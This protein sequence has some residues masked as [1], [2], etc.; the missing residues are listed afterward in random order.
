MPRKDGFPYHVEQG[1]NGG[2]RAVAEFA[3]IH[4]HNVAGNLLTVVE[5]VEGFYDGRIHF[6][7]GLMEKDLF[8]LVY[9][10]LTGF[11]TRLHGGGHGFER[12]FVDFP[13]LHLEVA[14]MGIRG[15][16]VGPAQ[17]D[18]VAFG[19]RM[20]L[21]D[22]AED[23]RAEDARALR[24]WTGG[25]EDNSARAVA[26]D[27]TVPVAGIDDPAES[28]GADD[29]AFPGKPRLYKGF[30]LDE[31]LE[32]AG[33]AEQQVVGYAS[34]VPD[35]KSALYAGGKSGHGIGLIGVLEDIAEI[36]RNDELVDGFGVRGGILEGSGGGQGGH[37]GS[38]HILM[39]ISSLGNTRDL[40]EFTD[41]LRGIDRDALPAFVIEFPDGKIPVR[42]DLARYIAACACYKDAHNV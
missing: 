9:I 37:I 5:L 25:F 12:E 21:A 14:R 38:S 31:T 24:R 19:Q 4:G 39:G 16:A 26:I 35:G 3:D 20:G 23:A 22:R 33:T 27:H 1:G 28:F 36:M 11:E 32:P 13:A 8:Y 42:P 2:D 34:G 41:K 17:G 7:V 6:F 29:Q 40:L 30:G 18:V 10:D 15:W